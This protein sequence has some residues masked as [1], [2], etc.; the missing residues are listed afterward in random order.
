MRHLLKLIVGGFLLLVLASHVSAQKVTVD[1]NPQADFSQYKTFMWIRPVH[2]RPDPLMESRITDAINA[3][4][5]AKGLQ[6]VPGGADIGIVTHVA[7]REEQTLQTFY[8]GFG[9]GWRWGLGWGEAITTPETYTIGTLVVDLFDTHTQQLIWRGVA[10]D[11]L[12]DKPEK[13]TEKMNKAVQKMFKDFPPRG[14]RNG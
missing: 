9:G 10:T 4:L 2:Y 6:M 3:A 12:S 8:D 7:T 1:F 5:T 11:T 14:R 13:D